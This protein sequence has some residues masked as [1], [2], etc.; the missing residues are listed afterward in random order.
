MRVIEQFIEAKTCE[1]SIRAM[2][3][4]GDNYLAKA[5]QIQAVNQINGIR[6]QVFL[7]VSDVLVVNCQE[8]LPQSHQLF[9]GN[10]TGYGAYRIFKSSVEI[11]GHLI[12]CGYWET[13]F[14][15]MISV[16][17]PKLSSNVPSK[18]QTTSVIDCPTITLN[19]FRRYDRY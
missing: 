13:M 5:C 1:A 6:K 7:D 16:S 19:P 17:I 18:S 9:F 11:T 10:V 4:V 8:V 3:S 14:V 15:I 2:C 12:H